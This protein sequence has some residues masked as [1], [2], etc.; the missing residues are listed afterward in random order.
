[1]DIK[2]LLGEDGLLLR[3]QNLSDAAESLWPDILFWG[4]ATG[5]NVC[6]C[7]HL[8]VALQLKGGDCSNQ[9]ISTNGS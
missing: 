6:V 2:Q 8:A 1:M 3:F 7:T 9:A 5:H 4:R